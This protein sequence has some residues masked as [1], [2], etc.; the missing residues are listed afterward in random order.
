MGAAV[1]DVHHR[2][3]EDIGVGAADVAV[4]R[5]TEFLGGRLRDSEGNAED[6]VRAELGL[7]RGAVEFD[8]GLVDSTL[9]GGHH[10]HD[11][12]GNDLVDILHSLENALAAIAG[13]AVAELESLVLTGGGTGRNGGDADKTAVKGNFNFDG[14]VAA[15]IE[16]LPTENLYDLHSFIELKRLCSL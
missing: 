15:G 16:D 2:D 14:G 13:T 4:Q 3:R 6:G 5:K 10:A 8:H 11:R 12:R 1:D 7:G 9:V